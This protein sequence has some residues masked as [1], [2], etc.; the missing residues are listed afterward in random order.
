MHEPADDRLGLQIVLAVILVAL[1]S[2]GAVEA[3]NDAIGF[4]MPRLGPDVDQAQY[5]VNRAFPEARH[6]RIHHHPGEFSIADLR[7]SQRKL[8][9]RRPLLGQHFVHPARGF[10]FE[11]GSAWSVSGQ[12]RSAGPPQ[13]FSGGWTSRCNSET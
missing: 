10:G 1:G 2:H 9:N 12:S 13:L 8:T 11:I 5:S 3:F 7:K 4:R 6:T